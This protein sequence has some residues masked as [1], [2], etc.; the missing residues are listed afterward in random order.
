MNKILESI[1]QNLVFLDLNSVSTKTFRMKLLVPA[2]VLIFLYI[3]NISPYT[4]YHWSSHILPLAQPI[5]W[6]KPLPRPLQARIGV[7]KPSNPLQKEEIEVV[8]IEEDNG[9]VEILEFTD[10][11]PD[12]SEGSGT[13]EPSFAFDCHQNK[14]WKHCDHF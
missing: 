12:T 11:D 1:I 14:N 6:T 10:E 7:S 5:L 2:S 8:V 9:D 13:E 3:D 4:T